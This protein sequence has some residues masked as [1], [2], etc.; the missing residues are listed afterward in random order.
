MAVFCRFGVPNTLV[1]DNRPCFASC[2]FTHFV[3]Q[4]N[5]QHI[6]SIPRYPQSNGKAENAV[7]TVERLFT[8][9]RAAGV[10]L[11]RAL[12]DWRNTP[13]EGKD[14]SPVQC[15]LGCRCKTL[16]PTPGA[17]LLPGFNVANDANKLRARK[18]H[19]RRYNKA[20][21]FT[22][23]VRQDCPRSFTC[24]KVEVS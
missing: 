3:V 24:W 7:H 17:I 1:T 9:C 19:Q 5:F 16:L 21:P 11:F 18:E 14:T 6:T 2:D 23:H 15:L 13:S 8:K 10:S 22:N 20:C 12:L 4:W